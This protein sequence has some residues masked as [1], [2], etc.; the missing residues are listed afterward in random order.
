M[1]CRLGDRI[2]V[3]GLADLNH[4]DAAADRARVADLVAM[5]RESLPHAAD[6]DDIESDW[7]GLRPMTPWSSPIIRRAGEGL[8]LNI[9]HGMLGWTLAMGSGERAAELVEER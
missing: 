9:G 7:A 6:Y 5:A 3:A 4:W 2:R 1:F 8:V